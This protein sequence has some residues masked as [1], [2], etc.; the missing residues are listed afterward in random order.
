MLLLQ[1]VAIFLLEYGTL[2]FYTLFILKS[3]Q[4]FAGPVHTKTDAHDQNN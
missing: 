4:F 2:L 1:L 3:S